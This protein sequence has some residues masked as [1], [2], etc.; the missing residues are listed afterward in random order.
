MFIRPTISR[1]FLILAV[2]LCA[3]VDPSFLSDEIPVPQTI[4]DAGRRL[5]KHYIP[6]RYPNGFASGAPGDYYMEE[7]ADQAIKDADEILRL[8]ESV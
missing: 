7:D 6:A 1:F 4:L 8:C 5:D 2:L 3:S